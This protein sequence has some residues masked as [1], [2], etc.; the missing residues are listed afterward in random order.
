MKLTPAQV[1]SALKES[2]TSELKFIRNCLEQE[3]QMRANM[4]KKA[5]RMHS[6]PLSSEEKNLIHNGQ[7]ID[8]IKTFRMRTGLDLKSSKDI[9]DA[10]R[11]TH[12]EDVRISS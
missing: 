6:I 7:I 10:Y 12:K 5:E 3:L 2:P 8:A 4:E 1:V 11:H 9:V